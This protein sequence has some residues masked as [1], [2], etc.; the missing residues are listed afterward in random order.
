LKVYDVDFWVMGFDTPTTTV[1]GQP[2]TV[3]RFRLSALGFR[4]YSNLQKKKRFFS[5]KLPGQ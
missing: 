2:P 3:N 1:N 5:T 4:L